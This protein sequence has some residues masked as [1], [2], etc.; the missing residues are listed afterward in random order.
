MLGN[1]L[2]YGFFIRFYLLFKNR[3]PNWLWYIFIVLI[4]LYSH[5]EIA[6]YS[7]VIEDNSLLKWS[8][9]TKNLL[10]ITILALF[11]FKETK[12]FRPKD[13]PAEITTKPDRIEETEGSHSKGDGFDQIRSKDKLSTHAEMLLKERSGRK[14]LD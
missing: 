10:L 7:K 2:K 13:T 11:L 12:I 9:I 4:I 8:F 14:E 1:A 3:F 6:E 5:S